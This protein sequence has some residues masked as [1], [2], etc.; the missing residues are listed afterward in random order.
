MS[1]EEKWP[2]DQ[3]ARR[4]GDTLH[5]DL[6]YPRAEGNDTAIQV[7]LMDVRAADDLLITYDFR[8]DGWVI[9]QER[10]QRVGGGCSASMDPPEWIEVAFIPA[11]QFEEGPEDE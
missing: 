10:I 1:K 4:Y 9:R 5:V 7:G 6:A 8:R 3:V 11:W 2:L